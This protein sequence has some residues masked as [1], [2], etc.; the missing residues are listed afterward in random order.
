M[1]KVNYEK[2][3]KELKKVKQE[4][5]RM[6][7]ELEEDQL[8]Y[9][10]VIGEVTRRIG[11]LEVELSEMDNYDGSNDQEEF[12][13][14]LSAEGVYKKSIETRDKAWDKR[15]KEEQDNH[16]KNL[17]LDSIDDCLANIENSTEISNE[18]D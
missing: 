1:S 13:Q 17:K 7:L 3:W 15:S 11:E 14:Q 4:E 12:A 18:E 16:I 10:G 6:F 9:T 2:I 5:Y 8:E